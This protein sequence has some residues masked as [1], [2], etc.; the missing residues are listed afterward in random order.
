LIKNI[1]LP[2][3]SNKNT[4]AQN[5]GLGLY[6]SYSIVKKYNGNITV[7]NMLHGCRFSITL[8]V[9]EDVNSFIEDLHG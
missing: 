3:Y 2:F 9:L 6:I 1:F 8:P 4:G 5:Q 7:K